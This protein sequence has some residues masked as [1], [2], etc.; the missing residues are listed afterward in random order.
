MSRYV[1]SIAKLISKLGSLPGIGHKTA[2]RLAFHI[3]NMDPAAARALAEAI[4][5][6]KERVH[7]CARCC[8]LTDREVCEICSDESRDHTKI[9]V[10]ESPSD[11]IAMERTREY[12][13]LYH[14]LH[15][16]ISPMENIG[17]EDIHLRDLLQ[18][19]Q[20]SPEVDEIILAN[21]ATVEG[22][23]TANYIARLVRPS[24]INC[25]RIAHGI[26]FGSSLEYADE[27]TLGRAIEGRTLLL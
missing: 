11:V 1:S 24:G 2:Q 16:A 15:G 8:D 22:E 25:S 6:A 3:L 18:R 21:N 10:V 13:G 9:C 7:L 20:S 26:P 19:L 17:P 23:A 27:V 4:I 5:E 14:V 12:R